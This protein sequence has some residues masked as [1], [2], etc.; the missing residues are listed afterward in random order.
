MKVNQVTSEKGKKMMN[1]RERERERERDMFD[2]C[3]QM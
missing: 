3:I 1:E 2:I